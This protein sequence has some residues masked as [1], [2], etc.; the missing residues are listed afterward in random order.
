MPASWRSSFGDG[1]HS[2]WDEVYRAENRSNTAAQYGRQELVIVYDNKT[3][4]EL[5]ENIG[6]SVTVEALRESANFFFLYWLGPNL[7]P[8]QFKSLGVGRT[9][10]GASVELSAISSRYA[11]TST[12]TFLLPDSLAFVG[13]AYTFPA[14]LYDE[15]KGLAEYSFST[16]QVD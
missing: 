13:V 12:A 3:L 11:K 10:Q 8:D 4:S 16:F 9:G 14:E 1:R 6:H 7:N 2:P 15:L 5:Q